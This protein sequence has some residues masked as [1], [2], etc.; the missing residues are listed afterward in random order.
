M[1]EKYLAQFQNQG[2]VE[3]YPEQNLRKQLSN[4]QVP[5]GYGVYLIYGVKADQR[6]LVYIGK[7]G[8]LLANGE[9]KSQSLAKRLLAKQDGEGRQKYFRTKLFTEGLSCLSIHWVV[10]VRPD[11]VMLPAKVEAGLLQ[12]YFDGHAKLP[13]WN[14]LI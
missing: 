4:A 14:K 7:S 3:F 11:S 1:F 8:T 6:R 9:W 2:V 13:P 10:T 5:D 12:I